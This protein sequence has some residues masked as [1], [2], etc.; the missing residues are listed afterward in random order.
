MHKTMPCIY[1]RPDTNWAD[2]F[3]MEPAHEI[4][5]LITHCLEKMFIL[6]TWYPEYDT[7]IAFISF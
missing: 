4:L 3:Q 6:Y 5:V 1:L 7:D 2:E